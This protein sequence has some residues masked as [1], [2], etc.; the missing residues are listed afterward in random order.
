MVQWPSKKIHHF[1][2]FQSDCETLGFELG[3]L[4]PFFGMQF[5]FTPSPCEAWGLSPWF[6]SEPSF[7]LV[8]VVAPLLETIWNR[9]VA[10][11]GFSA[12][13]TGR[14][15]RGVS[16][17]RAAHLQ[18]VSRLI[19]QELCAICSHYTGRAR[20]QRNAGTQRSTKQGVVN[21]GETMALS[22]ILL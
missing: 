4:I 20:G 8:L 3:F 13:T 19:Q 9:N 12:N 1:Y 21:V 16:S 7:V 22:Q 2:F 10:L 14:C 5:Y 18:A 17:G 15:I 6:G 11:L